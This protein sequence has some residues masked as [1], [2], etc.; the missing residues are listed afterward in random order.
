M[1]APSTAL[2][3]FGVI[4][5]YLDLEVPEACILPRISSERVSRLG[6]SLSSVVM[7]RDRREEGREDVQYIRPNLCSCRFDT[8]EDSLGKLLDLTVGGVEDYCDDWLGPP[9]QRLKV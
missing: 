6:L 4:T 3:S 8:F 7:S 1:I 5:G 9:H 2:K